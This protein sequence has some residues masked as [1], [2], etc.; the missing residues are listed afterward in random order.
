MG[1]Q[2]PEVFEITKLQVDANGKAELE[3]VG[4]NEGIVIE[5]NTT[6]NTEDWRPVPSPNN[7][8][9]ISGNSWT[10][11]LPESQ[12]YGFL[13]V[14]QEEGP[15]TAVIPFSTITFD[16]IGIHDSESTSYNANCIGC[17]GDRSKEVALDG[18]TPT[19]HSK[20]LQLF[21]QGNARC[22][23]CHET[24]SD[25]LTYSSSG[26]R[27]QVN[28]QERSCKVCHGLGKGAL[29]FYAQ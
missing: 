25:F 10:G 29:E 19:A 16:V 22:V 20:H 12:G 21:G 11:N 26:L 28:L 6:L 7:H 9:P 8:W 18:Q 14:R 5:I 2:A 15:F 17:H 24:G 27:E 4:A 23:F 1:G 13:R 3:W